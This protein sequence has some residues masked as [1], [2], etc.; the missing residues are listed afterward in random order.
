[1]RNTQFLADFESLYRKGEGHHKMHHLR[2]RDGIFQNIYFRFSESHSLA[3][4]EFFADGGLPFRHHILIL[5]GCSRGN[6]ANF[7]TML[8]E[9]C[10]KAFSGDSGAIVGGIELVDDK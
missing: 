5:G 3:F 8:P 9:V 7:I 10:S 6:D 2:P 4:D 1:M